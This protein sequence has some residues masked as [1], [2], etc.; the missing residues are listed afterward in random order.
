MEYV[1]LYNGI[2]MPM[3]GLGVFKMQDKQQ[4]EDVVYEAIKHGYRLIDTAMYYTNEDAVG[5]AVKKAT[6]EG[7]CKREELF[8]TTKLWPTDMKNED[9]AKRAIDTSLKKL[10]MD[11]IDLYLV[12]Q[13]LGDYFSGWRAMEDAYK[14]GLLKSIGVSNFYPNILANFCETVEIQPSVNQIELHPYFVQEDALENMK[15]YNVIP[16]AWAPLGGGR[17]DPFNN[18]MLK[19]IAKKHNK[20]VS[21]V[22]LKWNVQRGVVVLPKSVHLDRIK[23][24]FEIFDFTLTAE[25]MK[26]ISTLDMGYGD[27]RTKHFDPNFVRMCM[28]KK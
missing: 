8:I 11:Y 22:I 10:N 5:R 12:H 17:Y 14:Q 15:Y 4:C 27:T 1:T 9:T 21:Q 13:A 16:E 19:N 28:G 18:E 25:E 6:D 26:N 3:L 24:N 2:Q 7:I 23:E 20:T